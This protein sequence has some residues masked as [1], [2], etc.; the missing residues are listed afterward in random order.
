MRPGRVRRANGGVLLP[1]PRPSPPGAEG[2]CAPRSRRPEAAAAVR[3]GRTV[4]CR[5]PGSCD[6]YRVLAMIRGHRLGGSHRF[7][8]HPGRIGLAEDRGRNRCD[9]YPRFDRSHQS[10]GP[11]RA[12]LQTKSAVARCRTRAVG[13]GCSPGRYGSLASRLHHINRPR[14]STL[15][16]PF[17]AHR[18]GSADAATDFLRA[19]DVLHGTFDSAVHRHHGFRRDRGRLIIWLP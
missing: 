14:R 10:P 15:R 1:P 5:F 8:G 13:S 2:K 19:T 11:G 16:S 7:S 12:V 3:A 18:A 6:D 17:Q 9:P 4:S